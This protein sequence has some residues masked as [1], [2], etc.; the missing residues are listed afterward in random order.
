MIEPKFAFRLE[1]CVALYNRGIYLHP[2][3]HHCK[4]SGCKWERVIAEAQI[5]QTVLQGVLETVTMKMAE[6]TLM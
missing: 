5:A 6:A 2:E 3:S 4:E 1:S